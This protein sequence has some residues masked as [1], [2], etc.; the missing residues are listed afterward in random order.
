MNS[1]N[2]EQDKTISLRFNLIF[3]SKRFNILVRHLLAKSLLLQISNQE[4]N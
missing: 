4:H 3:N 2:V 1:I